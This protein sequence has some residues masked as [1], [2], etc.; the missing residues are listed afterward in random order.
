M[1]RTNRWYFISYENWDEEELFDMA[2]DPMQ[3]K[4]VASDYPDQTS[5]LRRDLKRWKHQITASYRP[6]MIR[7][8]TVPASSD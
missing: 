1:V 5:R 7:P 8:A 2:R 3:I 6:A 4:N